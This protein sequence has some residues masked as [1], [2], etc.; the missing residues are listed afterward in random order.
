MELK[1]CGNPAVY[2]GFCGF[3]ARE[4]VIGLKDL[5]AAGKQ[6]R[7]ILRKY[8]RVFLLA[9]LILGAVFLFLYCRAFF[10]VGMDWNDTF[11]PR[12]REQSTIVYSGA[13][14]WSD[15]TIT[16]DRISKTEMDISYRYMTSRERTYRLTISEEKDFWRDVR[17]DAKDGTNLFTGRYQQGNS[18]LYDKNGLPALGAIGSTASG[19]NPYLDFVPNYRVM[20]GIAVGEYDRIFGNVGYLLAGLLLAALVVFDVKHPILTARLRQF[21]MGDAPQRADTFELVCNC[22]RAV[23]VLVAFGFLLAAI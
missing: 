23:L 14:R 3:R 16:I 8:R 20:V 12:S 11:L 7:R 9:A 22:V 10:R 1:N 4:R 18:F 2:V 21:L 6:G 15:I 13:D 19:V 5:M 17:I